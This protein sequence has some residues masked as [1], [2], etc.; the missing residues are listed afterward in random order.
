MVKENNIKTYLHVCGKI[1]VTGQ[2]VLEQMSFYDYMYK[3]E[4]ISMGR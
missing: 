4:K 2:Q 1:L 3:L